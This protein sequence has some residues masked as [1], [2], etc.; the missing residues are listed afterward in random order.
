MKE[1]WRSFL[2]VIFDA[3]HTVEISYLC[4][5]GSLG[6]AVSDPPAV[7]IIVDDIIGRVGDRPS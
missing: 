4:D 5:I 1:P 7:C 3:L 2:F 6:R